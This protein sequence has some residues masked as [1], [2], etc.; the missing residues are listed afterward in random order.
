[1]AQHIDRVERA[2]LP[3]LEKSEFYA[4]IRGGDLLFCSADGG[5]GKVIEGETHS[6]WSHVL[7]L[8]LPW[9]TCQH[10]LTLEATLQRGVHVGLADDYIDRYP[11]RLVLA[12][13]Y[14][15]SPADILNELNIGL[16]LL[17][18]GYDWQTEVTYAAHKLLKCLPIAEPPKELYCSSLQQVMSRATPYPIL[19]SGEIPATPEQIWTDPSVEAVCALAL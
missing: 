11:G 4:S 1:M 18:E 15:L 5:I 7:M 9:G 12:R 3:T 14:A 8:W 6:P 19:T 2:Q 13:R 17:D 16:S 10:W